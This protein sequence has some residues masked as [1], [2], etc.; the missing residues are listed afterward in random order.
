MGGFDG[1]RERDGAGR[2]SQPSTP[3]WSTRMDRRRRDRRLVVVA[4]VRRLRMVGG[5][6]PTS[7]RRSASQQTPPPLPHSHGPR[8]KNSTTTNN[9]QPTTDNQQP[10]T[11]GAEKTRSSGRLLIGGSLR[12]PTNHRS[13]SPPLSGGPVSIGT[14]ENLPGMTSSPNNSVG[15]KVKFD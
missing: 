7:G 1:E 9:Q 12:P 8:L 14:R 11:A 3:S 4:V 10:T 6:R 15:S 2:R 5:V 13:P